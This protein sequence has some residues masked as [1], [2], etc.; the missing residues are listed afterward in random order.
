MKLIYE[1]VLYRDSSRNEKW[2]QSMLKY[3]CKT[4]INTNTHAINTH[5]VILYS[6]VLRG[7]VVEETLYFSVIRKWVNITQAMWIITFNLFVLLQAKIL[8]WTHTDLWHCRDYWVMKCCNYQ[9]SLNLPYLLLFYWTSIGDFLF[10]RMLFNNSHES[11]LAVCQEMHST[12]SKL[13]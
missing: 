5:T 6:S 7:S 10:P 4:I 1:H 11:H 8:P 13:L 9:L 3:F 12:L 2:R